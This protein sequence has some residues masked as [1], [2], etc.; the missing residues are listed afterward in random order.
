MP[1]V[2][3]ISFAKLMI[4][5][6]LIQFYNFGPLHKLNLYAEFNFKISG[7]IACFLYGFYG[8]LLLFKKA[9]EKMYRLP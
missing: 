6:H 5:N 4:K 2:R 3:F 1:V 7:R 9:K 8:V